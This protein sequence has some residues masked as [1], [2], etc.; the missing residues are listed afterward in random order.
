M[1]TAF[2][3]SRLLLRLLASTSLGNKP[4]LFVPVRD[5]SNS[6]SGGNS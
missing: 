5:Q 6:V 3:A 1:F 2:F 4:N